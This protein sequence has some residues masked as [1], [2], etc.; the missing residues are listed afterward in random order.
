MIRIGVD[1]GGTFTDFVFFD[2][3]QI[4]ILKIPSTPS[5]PSKAILEGL[6][7]KLDGGNDLFVIHGTTVATNAL[8]ERKGGRIGLVTTRG[9]EDI[10]FIGRQTRKKLYDLQGEE[11][12]PLLPR[13]H[14]FGI[15]ER[16]SAKGKIEQ[17]VSLEKLNALIKK[18]RSKK[19][20]AVAVSFINS[21][22]NPKNEQIVKK[23]LK[24]AGIQVCISSEILPEY[25]EYE[26]TVVTAVNTYLIPVMARYLQ[27]L[28]AHLSS[29]ELRI[30]QS[31]EGYISAK[32]ARSE[33]IRTSLSGPAGGVVASSHLGRAID[34]KTLI[35]F[36]MGGTSTDVSLLD[37]EIK[38]TSEGHI[39]DF[40]VRLPIIDIHTVGAG[41]GSIA[42]LDKGGSL[43]VGPRSAGAD[44]G[45]ACYGK[46]LLP[47]VTDANLV[48]GRISPRFF[49]GG[50]MT[51]YP[52]KSKKA[53]GNLANKINKTL[54]E[55]A[56]GIVAIANANMEKAIRVISIERGHDPRDFN[57]ISFGGAGGIHA[58]EM[59]RH[60]GI[61]RVIV[62]KNAGVFSAL[63]FLLADSIKDQLRS[64]LRPEPHVSDNKLETSFSALATHCS[65]DMKDEGFSAENIHIRRYLELR[66]T[67]Q[68]YEI[69][70]PYGPRTVWKDS[71]H[72]THDRL[73]SYHHKDRDIEIV[74]IR[75][76]AIGTGQ[77]I[78]L[79]KHPFRSLD[80]S[81][82][83]L[84]YQ[85]ICF[86][87]KKTR[88]PVYDRSLLLSG[89]ELSGPALIADYES[90]AFV[91][92]SF[93]A[94]VDEFLNIILKEKDPK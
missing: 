57:L 43:R 30:M 2:N 88:A 86:E 54:L 50:H 85:S 39:G 94:S 75:T 15:T 49:L 34:V 62:P 65:D 36:D 9:Y 4:D 27:Q 76:T 59:S 6:R 38:R 82:A 3:G 60:L 70:V 64:I 20:D 21:Y 80:A 28:E 26:R 33:P 22:A 24:K 46:G 51:L 72:Q 81:S 74:N 11:K 45:P 47:T 87:G 8:L 83:V 41:G 29:N 23:S 52:E 92:P 66:Y 31:N 32:T 91:P 25:R 61:P 16:T 10:L 53:I 68:S 14:C 19:F 1:T 79:K 67:G 12:Y 84:H 18:I 7:S 55:T 73:Y 93:S 42:Y 44:P 17:A 35:T 78:V 89:N 58:A 71:F 63:G 13:S 37:G 56:E 5:D 69:T 48:L 77:K 90:T 40:P